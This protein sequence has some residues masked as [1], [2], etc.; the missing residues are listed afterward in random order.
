TVPTLLYYLGIILA[1]EMDARRFRTHAVAI[2]TASARKLLL[3]YGYHFS[4]LIAI[5]VFMAMGMTAFRAVVFATALQFLL[6][7]PA[8]GGAQR[9][10]IIV[11]TAQIGGT[12]PGLFAIIALAWAGSL[13]EELFFR[14]LLLNGLQRIF[15][16]GRVATTAAG[17]V[18]ILVFAS[19]HGY[20]GWAGMVD[21]G[22]Y[23]GLAMTLLYLWRDRR[24]TACIVAHAGWNTIAACTIYA[25]YA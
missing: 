20:Q 7:I 5:V 4:S 3:R 10:D 12:L 1:I 15:G 2:E 23:G 9:S 25:A 11:N 13:S 14:G 24:L 8:T 18:V 17:L 21:T 6:I 19:L 22:L 16:G